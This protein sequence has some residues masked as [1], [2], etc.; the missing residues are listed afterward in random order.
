LGSQ[1]R[2]QRR[3]GDHSGTIDQGDYDFGQCTS[4]NHAGA[5]AESTAAVLTS[6]RYC[7]SWWIFSFAVRRTTFRLGEITLH[8]AF[9]SALPFSIIASICASSIFRLLPRKTLASLRQH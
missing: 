2:W 9:R 4:A 7:L 1:S 5:G 6:R 8:V 3:D